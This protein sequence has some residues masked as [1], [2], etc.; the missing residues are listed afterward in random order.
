MNKFPCDDDWFLKWGDPFPIKFH[1]TIYIS[2]KEFDY[3]VLHQD[4]DRRIKTAVNCYGQVCILKTSP[5]GYIRYDINPKP[6]PGDPETPKDSGI[7]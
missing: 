5:E 6:L 2:E 1:R 7:R 3:L 4:R